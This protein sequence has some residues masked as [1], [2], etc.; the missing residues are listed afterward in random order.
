MDDTR[1]EELLGRRA[2]GLRDEAAQRAA[3]DAVQGER[4]RLRRRRRVLVLALAAAALLAVGILWRPTSPPRPAPVFAVAL[5]DEGGRDLAL[6]GVVRGGPERSPFPAR[7]LIEVAPQADGYALVL[8]FD[9]AGA[10]HTAEVELFAGR[11]VL[12]PIDL[13]TGAPGVSGG[14]LDWI[15]AA[16]GE[17]A[18]LAELGHLQARVPPAGPERRA[19]LDA[20]VARHSAVDG[21]SVTA[22]RLD[23][24]AAR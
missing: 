11:A 7:V 23:V 18:K 2:A 10:P 4:A 12:V 9:A 1:L 5:L 17:R 16:S 13:G 24:E 21:L 8:L 6:D 19:A 3:W 14:A 15:V 20:M 22:G